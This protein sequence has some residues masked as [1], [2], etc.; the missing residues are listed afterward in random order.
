M[1]VSGPTAKTM[2]EGHETESTVSNSASSI[3]GQVENV[4][5]WQTFWGNE[6]GNKGA[7]IGA[8]TIPS[9]VGMDDDETSGEAVVIEIKADRAKEYYAE[10]DGCKYYTALKVREC[11]ELT[12]RRCSLAVRLLKEPNDSHGARVSWSHSRHALPDRQ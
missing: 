8:G 6:W 12:L 4:E 3:T 11:I 9:R 10:R 5:V 7:L 1:D 2:H